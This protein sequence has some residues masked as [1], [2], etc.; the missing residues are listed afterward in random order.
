M[1][2]KTNTSGLLVDDTMSNTSENAVQ[3]KVIKDYVDATDKEL[4]AQITEVKN[5][6]DS[7]SGGSSVTI[8]DWSV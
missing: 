4:Q 2:G 7:G 8:R 1:L 6:I 3:N 5:K